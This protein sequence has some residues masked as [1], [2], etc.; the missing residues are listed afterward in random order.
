M[1]V[2]ADRTYTPE[3][4]LSMDDGTAYELVDGQLV[5]RPMSQLSVWVGGELFT[6]LRLFLRAHPIGWLWPADLGYQ[7]FPDS[8]KKV[9]RPDVSFIRIGR[10]PEG[11]TSEGYTHIAPDLAVEI[12]SPNDLWSDLQAKVNEYLA[13]G[14]ALVW[15][16]DPVIRIAFVYRPDGTISQLRESDALDGEDV[17]PGFRCPLSSIL[18]KVTPSE[19]ARKDA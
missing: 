3:D 15:L 14:V 4:L 16:I 6:E 2:V 10:K 18:P 5:E 7:C 12:V 9:R 17:I 13:A 8:P 1:H 11:P 19:E